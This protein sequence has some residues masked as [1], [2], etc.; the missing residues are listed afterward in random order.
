MADL[1]NQIVNNK[2]LT[3]E[4]TGA[5]GGVEIDTKI[6]KQMEPEHMAELFEAIERTARKCKKKCHHLPKDNKQVK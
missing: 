1:T 4:V 3:I 5:M 6:H 2:L